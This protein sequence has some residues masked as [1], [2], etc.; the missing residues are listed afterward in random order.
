VELARARRAKGLTQ[1]VVARLLDVDASTISRW[2]RGLERPALARFSAIAEVYGLNLSTLLH[3]QAGEL[4]DSIPFR[5]RGRQRPASE[6]FA[7]IEERFN[8]LE[9]KLESIERLLNTAFQRLTQ[10]EEGGDEGSLEG[11]SQSNRSGA[12]G[13]KGGYLDLRPNA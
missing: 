3:L 1:V 13:L 5:Y 8:R 12:Q 6:V 2:E 7:D 11:G 9:G 4:E 10:Q